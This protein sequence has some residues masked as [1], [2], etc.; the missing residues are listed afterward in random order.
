MGQ[1]IDI[2]PLD[3]ALLDT[4]GGTLA[5]AFVD[6]PMFEWVFPDPASRARKLGVLNRI[7]LEYGLRYGLLVT[8]SDSGRGVAIWLRPG[9]SLTPLGMA[10]CGMLSAPV[11]VGFAA[12]GRFARANAMME[13][14]HKQAMGGRP[15]WQLLIVGVDPDLQGR[16]LGAA[17]VRDGL[18]RADRDGLA[19]YLD[20]SKA[21]NVPFYEHLGF[22][23]VDQVQLGKGGPPGWGMRREPQPAGIG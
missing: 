8:E 1:P 3:R 13:P 19:C 12:L 17:L 2:A 21:A 18:H 11:K 20:T 4:A 5:R 14:V 15:H 7:P 9:Q 23:T 22:E 6:D 10:R 16:G